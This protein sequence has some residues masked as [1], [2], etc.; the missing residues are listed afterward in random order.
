MLKN[1]TH[2]RMSGGKA[3]KWSNSG[4]TAKNTTFSDDINPVG[5]SLTPK[6]DDASWWVS[7]LAS[8][9]FLF[10]SEFLAT[11]NLS[12]H[13]MAGLQIQTHDDSITQWVFPFLPLQP[14]RI[15]STDSHPTT[16][17]DCGSPHLVG[18]CLFT[19]NH[20]NLNGSTRGGLLSDHP[21][22]HN[23]SYSQSTDWG[24]VLND[25]PTGPNLCL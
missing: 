16:D 5:V 6:E 22:G 1:C 4:D 15:L 19:T 20:T 7:T 24:W 3:A 10:C 13:T 14:S 11:T 18:F 2:D 8:L 21:H 25:I 23:Y 12:N 9:G 17:R